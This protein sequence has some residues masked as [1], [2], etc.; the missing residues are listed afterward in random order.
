M[1]RAYAVV[2]RDGGTKDAVGVIEYLVPSEYT[3]ATPCYAFRAEQTA[4]CL[5]LPSPGPDHLVSTRAESYPP[6]FYGLVGWPTLFMSGVS[7]LYMMRAVAAAGVAFLLALALQNVFE[8]RNCNLLLIGV[9]LA[10]TPA[11]LFLGGS[12][13]PSG[14]SIAAGMAIW[15]GGFA[16]VRTNHLRRLSVAVAKV[17]APLCLFLL[18][19][20]DAI[21]WAVLIVATLVAITGPERRRMLLRSRWLW[22]WAAGAGAIALLQLRVS[23]SNTASDLPPTG[24]SLARAW[25]EM[26]YY[27]EQ[28]GG[29]VLGWLD[30]ELPR[31]VLDVFTYGTVLLAIA[32]LVIAPRRIAIAVLG[33]TAIVI[34]APLAI[35]ARVHP[36]FQG[37][38]LLPVAV[39][40]PLLAG[41]GLAETV[42]GN[43][44]VKR[45]PI[46]ALPL[47]AAAH[48]YAFA[49]ALR[50]YTVGAH[51]GW[52]FVNQQKWNPPVLSAT[53]LVFVYTFAIIGLFGWMYLCT[54]RI[55]SSPRTRAREEQDT[56]ARLSP[57]G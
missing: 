28:M 40:L 22:G 20:R 8:M 54:N 44:W 33:V 34:V 5:T 35:G 24:G 52:F 49:Q 29:G 53:S 45:L 2:H 6:M 26:P 32:A 48:I 42:S 23:V 12:V 41:L 14:L 9:A 13:N 11:V 50:R 18:L 55:A 31:F 10:L 46:L 17:G 1:V 36:Y 21:V 39:G 27:I 43:R 38:Y 19:R 3:A 37:R 47:V 7:G 51:G 16:L 30:T 4:D 15:T 25:S 56:N 57:A